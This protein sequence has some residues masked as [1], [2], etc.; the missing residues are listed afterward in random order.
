[1]AKKVNN[2]LCCTR[3]SIA[4]RLRADPCPLL[5]LVRHTCSA[6]SRV[7]M[8]STRSPVPTAASSVQGHKDD[9]GTGLKRSGCESWYCSAWRRESSGGFIHVHKYLAEGVK[10]AELDSSRCYPVTGQE[11]LGTNWNTGNFTLKKKGSTL[12]QWRS[13]NGNRLPR[14]AVE[15][16]S[17]EVFKTQRDSSMQPS[18]TAEPWA[19]L[20][21]GKLQ[22]HFPA[23]AGLGL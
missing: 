11:A 20:G 5:G 6:R 3:Q 22:R 17:L 1:M 13:S 12:L 4:S 19:E 16:P 23:T 8:L 10:T 18:L 15:S 21:P 7:W 2:I 14:E 9:W